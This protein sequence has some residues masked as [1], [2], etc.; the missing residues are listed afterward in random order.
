MLKPSPYVVCLT[1]GQG[2]GLEAVIDR[3]TAPCC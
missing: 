2:C 3:A 1:A